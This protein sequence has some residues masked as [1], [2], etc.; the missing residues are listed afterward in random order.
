MVW[1]EVAL[2]GASSGEFEA[3]IADLQPFLEQ[4]WRASVSPRTG[5][6]IYE[7]PVAIVLY[8]E[9]HRFLLDSII[10]RAG[11]TEANFD[12]ILI[13]SGDQ[14]YRMDFQDMIRSHLENKAAVSIAALPV[15]EAEA[16]SCGIM[17]IEST[18]RVIDFEEK[19]KTRELLVLLDD[20]L[21]EPL[22]LGLRA[23][24]TELQ[25]VIAATGR[26]HRHSRPRR[27]HPRFRCPR[28][29]LRLCGPGGSNR[30][31]FR[32][33]GGCGGWSRRW[34]RVTR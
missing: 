29:S 17:R 22:R 13:L 19:P 8:R 25:P 12:L 27:R 30:R 32:L 15:V 6:P 4:N 7:R 16:R 9:D 31:R 1:H 33:N 26:R 23:R 21:P 18:G 14:L 2:Q 10:P 24:G 3:Q 11:R 20:L 5:M 34:S 28:L